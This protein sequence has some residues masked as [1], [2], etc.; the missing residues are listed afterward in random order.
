MHLDPRR[1]AALIAGTLP[2]EEARA[3]AEHLARDCER[4]ERFLAEL[5]EADALDGRSDAAIAKAYP[6]PPVPGAELEFARILRRVRTPPRRLLPAV[7]IAIAASLLLAGLAGLWV[8]RNGPGGVPPTAGWDG[9]KG[10]AAAPVQVRLRA[11]RLDASGAAVPVRAGESLDPGAR[12]LFEVEADRG[13]DVVLVRV[14][15]SGAAEL[16]W[17]SRIARG[18]TVPTVGGKAAAYPVAALTGRQRFAVIAAEGGLDDA[19]VARATSSLALS[20]ALRD[21]APA[22]AGVSVDVLELSVR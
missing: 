11:V 16:V 12:L 1:H 17:R 14:P 7:P 8:Q 6:P 10:D 4:C 22:T 2:P 21:G 19:R 13:A 15:P 5:G 3:L 18:R 9:V 20:A